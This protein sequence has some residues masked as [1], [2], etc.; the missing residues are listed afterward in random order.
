MVYRF[1]IFLVVGAFGTWA[2]AQ[3]RGT[4]ASSTPSA[5]PAKA[6]SSKG[7][8]A[9]LPAFTSEREAAALSFVDQNHPEL[10]ALL[11]RLNSKKSRKEYERAI[12]ELFRASESLA[13]SYE[14][15]PERHAYDLQ[16]WKLESRIRLLAARFAMATDEPTKTQLTS[17]IRAAL[18]EQLE[19]RLA[20]Q[21]LEQQRATKRVE[22]M[23]HL[24][25]KMQQQGPALVERSLQ[26]LL[27][28]PRQPRSSTTTR[29]SGQPQTTVKSKP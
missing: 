12:R 13:A 15:D 8:L 19:V 7:T 29:D 26:K 3:D 22:R 6:N 28:P 10:G 17:E 5:K 11:K 16:L 4:A 21:M 9:A 27:E 18:T 1:I 2:E 14:K 20:R 23:N 25:Q 24:I